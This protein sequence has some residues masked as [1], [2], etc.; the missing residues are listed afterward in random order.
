M[1]WYA[2]IGPWLSFLNGCLIEDDMKIRAYV[3]VLSISTF[4]IDDL[5]QYTMYVVDRLYHS[6]RG[7]KALHR[8]LCSTYRV[9]NASDSTMRYALA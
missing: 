1:Y 7:N 8:F 5:V 6:M 2:L 9:A 3:V 4:S